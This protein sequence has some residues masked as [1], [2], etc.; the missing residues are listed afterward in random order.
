MGKITFIVG[1][2]RSGKSEYAVKLARCAKRVAFIATGE[3]LDGEM[4]RR[5]KLHKRARP[6]DW[7]TFEEPLKVASLLKKIPSGYDM[8]IIDCLT[9]LV[10]NLLLK[11]IA[12]EA[13]EKEIASLVDE[14]KTRCG[15][16][17]VVSNEVGLGVVPATRLGRLFRDI[18]GCANKIVAGR[19][20]HVVFMVS[21]MPLKIKKEVRC[22]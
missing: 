5:I 11:K 14:L 4:A 7:H 3:A 21:G 19:S 13:I 1:G 2:A 8:V 15:K 17:I 18:A 9:L 10:S 22:G 16:A 20:D 6:G 12:A